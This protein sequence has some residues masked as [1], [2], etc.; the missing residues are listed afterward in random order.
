MIEWAEIQR[1]CNAIARE[2]K[3]RRI[4]VFGSYAYGQPTQDSDVDVMV[5]MPFSKKR[6]IRP[7]LEI[8]RQIAAGFPVDILVREPREIARR[9]RQGDSFITDVIT[10]GKVMYEAEHA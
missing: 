2:F 8:R 7:S 9:L 5:V 3:P 6:R 10:R 4:V 1:Y